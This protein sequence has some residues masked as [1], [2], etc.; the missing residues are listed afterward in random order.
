MKFLVNRR[1]ALAT[2]ASLAAAAVMP[3]W[4][5]AQ[6]T[7]RFAA[8]FSDKDIRAAL[9]IGQGANEPRQKP[10]PLSNY[11]E[12]Q[13]FTPRMLPARTSIIRNPDPDL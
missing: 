10:S 2:G 6:P 4:A 3:A 13:K 8:V 7:L 5:Q 9:H 12:P 11:G 1:S